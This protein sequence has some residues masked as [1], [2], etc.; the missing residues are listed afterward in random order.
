[1]MKRVL[2]TGGG[3]FVGTVL[4]RQLLDCG[5]EVSVAGRNRY[6]HL[7]QLE[8]CCLVGDIAERDFGER[9]CQ[10]VD[11]VFHTAAKAGIWGDFE[12]YKRTNIDGTLNIL[13]GCRKNGVER[14]I[15]TSTPSVV[16][17]YHDIEG[18]DETLPYGRKHLC[19][20][21]RSKT[22]AERE[23]L[24]SSDQTLATCAIRPHLIWGPNDPHLIPR[25]LERGKAKALKIVGSGTNLVDITYVD[26]VAHAHVLA[27]KNLINS[28][29]SAGQAYFIGQERPVRLWDWINELFQDMNIAPVRRKIC[30]PVAFWAGA[31]LELFHTLTGNDHEP[32]MTRFLAL[33]LA[34]SHYFSQQKATRELG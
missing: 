27:A 12:S 25:L 15:Y 1:M 18:A 9:I 22:I 8:V 31:V 13:N 24:S 29:I 6:P 17:D 5:C 16:F 11:T 7:E 28:S 3:G 26:N 23:V 20:Y 19:H 10:G 21:A 33:Q 30:F 4:V 34:R 14:L 2:V 32:K